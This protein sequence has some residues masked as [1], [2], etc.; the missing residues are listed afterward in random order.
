MSAWPSSCCT[1]RRSAPFC[2]RWLAKAWR[3]TCGE[4]FAAAM[5]ARAAKRLQVA[6][7]DLARQI[8]ALRGGRK[9]PAGCRRAPGSRVALGEPGAH[10]RRAP[11]P[12]AAPC[13]PCCPCRARRRSARRAAPP[14]TGRRP[15]RRR[16]GRWRRAPRPAHAGAARQAASPS[17]AGIGGFRGGPVEQPAGLGLAHRLRQRPV[18]PRA[19]QRAGRV[20]GAQ[21]FGIEELEELPQRRKLARLRGRR[22]AAR[23]DVA[24]IGAQIGGAGVG[25]AARQSLGGVLEVAAVGCSVLSAAPRSA[26]IISRKASMRAALFIGYA[27]D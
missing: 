5:P 15:A 19:V 16:A 1:A 3:S 21:A 23:G 20:V 8:A 10:R 13:A 25:E 22:E 14:S 27:S 6:G 4:I 17:P 7:K 11:C 9:Q 2:S 24:E 12:T 26:L 18:L